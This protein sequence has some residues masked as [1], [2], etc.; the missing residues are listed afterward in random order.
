MKNSKLC[1]VKHCENAGDPYLCGDHW[2]K[3][4][5]ETRDC[6]RLKDERTSERYKLL[7][8]AI[9][10]GI[11]PEYIL[12]YDDEYGSPKLDVFNILADAIE[13]K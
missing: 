6:L 10:F 11:P 3:L 12:I 1:P 9:A 8:Q 4:S 5:S 2:M 7:R 13:D